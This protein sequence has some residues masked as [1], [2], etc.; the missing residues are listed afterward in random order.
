MDWNTCIIFCLQHFH[1][2][3]PPAS[4]C[5]AA[6]ALEAE[7]WKVVQQTS[8]QSALYPR[9]SPPMRVGVL[10][11]PLTTF[12]IIGVKPPCAGR[13]D[14]RNV[15]SHPSTFNETSESRINQYYPLHI[16]QRQR[17]ATVQ[18]WQCSG[19]YDVH[20]ISRYSNF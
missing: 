10:M 2:Y 15:V 1:I 14:F 9:A 11:Q 19:M 8:Q 17:D 3:C 6:Q 7:S 20:G 18:R 12:G 5:I 13:P 4:H 16:P